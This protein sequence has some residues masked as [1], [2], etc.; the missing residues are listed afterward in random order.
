MIAWTTDTD[1][2]A[3]MC[4]WCHASKVVTFTK[5][6]YHL[7][8][9]LTITKCLSRHISGIFVCYSLSIWVF[10][11]SYKTADSPNLQYIE[12]SIEVFSLSPAATQGIYTIARYYIISVKCSQHKTYLKSLTKK[13]ACEDMDSV[14]DLVVALSKLQCDAVNMYRWRKM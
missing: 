13:S 14:K 12:F 11:Q 10:L 4:L 5:S 9:V 3:R 7:Q 8:I 6:R 1:I 2:S